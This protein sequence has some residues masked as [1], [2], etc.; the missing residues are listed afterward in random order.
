MATSFVLWIFYKVYSSAKRGFPASGCQPKAG[1]FCEHTPKV[2]NMPDASDTTKSIGIT[3]SYWWP[4]LCNLINTCSCKIPG[5]LTL[6][7]NNRLAN[8]IITYHKDCI[9]HIEIAN[10]HCHSVAWARSFDVGLT[11]AE[12]QKLERFKPTGNIIFLSTLKI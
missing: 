3:G 4:W 5:R 11:S 10:I 2:E 8:V 7:H 6:A 12:G 1:Y 9:I